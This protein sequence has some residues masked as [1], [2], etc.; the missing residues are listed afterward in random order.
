MPSMDGTVQ[1]PS[2][3]GKQGILG[4][5]R[6]PAY[7]TNAKPSKVMKDMRFS[8]IETVLQSNAMPRFVPAERSPAGHAGPQD[9][10]LDFGQPFFFH[11]SE[12]FAAMPQNP[13]RQFLA[14][15]AAL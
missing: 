10:R 9:I 8:S 1:R 4:L 5:G 6:S 7:E 11:C 3:P 13:R 2:M 14:Q 15:T 12:G